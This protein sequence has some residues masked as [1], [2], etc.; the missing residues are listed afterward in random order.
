M[1][2][3]LR[4]AVLLALCV[5]A[6]WP[7][8]SVAQTAAD[9]FS[10]KT[11]KF[12][13]THEPGGSCD[14]YARLADHPSCQAHARASGDDGA[15]SCRAPAASS[16]RSASLDKAAQDGTELAILPRDIAINQLLR[17]DTAKYDARRFNWIG[18][19][20]DAMPA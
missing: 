20:V 13:I 11:I 3:Y 15:V 6:G 7:A 18:T 9:F 4:L 14:L 12:M 8:R 17:P 1:L 19:L 10:Q 5:A 2:T 16:A